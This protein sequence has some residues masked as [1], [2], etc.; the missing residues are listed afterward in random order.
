MSATEVVRRLYDAFARGD[1]PEVLELLDGQVEWHEAEGSPYNLGPGGFV[2]PDAVVTNL[3][4]KMG[5]DWTEFAVHPRAFHE[6]RG[7]VVVEVRYTATHASG[8]LLDSQACHVWTVGNGRITKFQQYMDTAQMRRV[9]GVEPT[10][11]DGAAT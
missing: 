8:R 3:F 6:A 1:L 2:G 10:A 7:V 11:A 5:T 4:E 9:M